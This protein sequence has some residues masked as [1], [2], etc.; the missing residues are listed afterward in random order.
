[1]STVFKA[2]SDPTRRKVLELL[3]G[4]PRNA[5]ELAEHFQISKPTMSGH[6][7]VLREAGLVTSERDGKQ[8]VYELQLSV[9]EDAMLA[10][11]KAFGWDL[12]TS[13]STD[14]TAA[15]KG[16]TA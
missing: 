4:G 2:L 1:M 12:K 7:A 5:G 13:D 14:R 15:E 9:L 10:F 6:F 11:T 8:V 16:E 3:K